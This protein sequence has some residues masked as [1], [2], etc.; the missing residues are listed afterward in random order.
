MLP[1]LR[2]G[3][4][5]WA[6]ALDDPSRG[7]FLYRIMYTPAVIEPA[8]AESERLSVYADRCLARPAY[9]KAMRFDAD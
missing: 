7:K 8:M 4:V 5:R 1:V 3:G 6:P 2:Y 9:Q